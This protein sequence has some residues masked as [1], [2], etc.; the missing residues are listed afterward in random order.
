M[1]RWWSGGG[2]AVW[3]VLTQ[4]TER[5][6]CGVVEWRTAERVSGGAVWSSEVMERWSDKV[7]SKVP[8]HQTSPVQLTL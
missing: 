5:S 1:E 6:N 4:A 8:T 2:G 3:A 7:D